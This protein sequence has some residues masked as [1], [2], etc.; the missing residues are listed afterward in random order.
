[1]DYVELVLLEFAIVSPNSAAYTASCIAIQTEHQIILH[2]YTQSETRTFYINRTSDERIFFF[3][4]FLDIL[5]FFRRNFYLIWYK[6]QP[7]NKYT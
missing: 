4:T 5:D 2:T 6:L 7:M 1:M 3:I